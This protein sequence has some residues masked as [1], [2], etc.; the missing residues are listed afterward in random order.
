MFLKIAVFYTLLY[1]EENMNYKVFVIGIE[2]NSL[3]SK[4]N[5]ESYLSSLG[6]WKKISDGCYIVKPKPLIQ[7]SMELRNRIP[8]SLYMDGQLFV[9]RTSIDASW[10]VRGDVSGWLSINL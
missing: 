7:S 1:I 2:L 4:N 9:M 10:S 8:P 6:E 3:Q 5:F